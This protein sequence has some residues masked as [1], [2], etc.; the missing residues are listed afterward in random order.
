MRS[1]I[2]I[3]DFSLSAKYHRRLTRSSSH[4]LQQAQWKYLTWG[5]KWMDTLMILVGFVLAYLVRFNANL[6]FFYAHEENSQL[7]FYL[8]L[9]LVL[10]PIWRLTFRLY[11]LYAVKENMSRTGLFSKLFSATTI[12]MFVL[13]VADYLIEEIVVARGWLLLIWGFVYLL[14]IFGRII[15]QALFYQLRL[16][17]YFLIPAI[18][19]GANE[20]S[21]MLARQFL[22]ER[23]SG[24]QLMGF[25]AD[26]VPMGTPVL[27]NLAVLGPLNEVEKITRAIGVE[28]VIVTSSAVTNLQILSLFQLFGMTD[29]VNMRLSSGLYEIITTG[30]EIENFASVPL[31]KVNE[32][33]LTGV[34]HFL[35][36]TLDYAFALAAMVFVIPL[37]IVLGIL[38]K[39][40]SPGPIFHRR[41]VM[42]VHGK[43]I[44][45]LKFRTMYV[46]GD[47]ILE[48]YPELKKQLETEHK[49]KDDPRVT[50]IGRIIRTLSLDEFPQFFNVLRGEMSVVG[51]RMISP[52]EMVEYRKYGMNLLTVRPG[53]TGLW[54]VSGRSDISYQER[55]QMDMYYIRNWSIWMD[56]QLI[57]RTPQA[58]I[59]RRGAY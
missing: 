14:T 4:A 16:R 47:Q 26:D 56:L 44:D 37:T 21:R 35:K 45:A 50:R 1:D 40:D 31:V 27:G 28:E 20:E 2:Y 9:G 58:M 11:G 51:P 17:G 6:P 42:G 23:H 22:N 48:N 13:I 59:S 3:P 18:I 34:D 10:L 55:V 46:N 7:L 38:I 15:M 53:I 25:V 57:F 5:Y 33:R 43:E 52:E 39:L 24:L 19:V 49:L 8:F 41:R 54:Q 29:E 12:P 32:F 30:L 36:F